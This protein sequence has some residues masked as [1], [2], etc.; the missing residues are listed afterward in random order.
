M[1]EAAPIQSKGKHAWLD[2]Y[3]QVHSVVIRIRHYSLLTL[4]KGLLDSIEGD[5]RTDLASIKI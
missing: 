5:G 3:L 2:H 4:P 1:T